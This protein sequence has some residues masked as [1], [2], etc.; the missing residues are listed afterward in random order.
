[1][2]HDDF[3]RQVKEFEEDVG[4]GDVLYVA[5][6]E[7]LEED[8][9]DLQK[10]DKKRVKRAVRAFLAVWGRMSRNV[11]R[12]DFNWDLLLEKIRDL[13]DKPKFLGK[14][15]LT[16]KLDNEAKIMAEMYNQLRMK[17]LSATGIS[18]VMHLLNPEVFVMWDDDI[19]KKIR[20]NHFSASANGYLDFLTWIQGELKEAI[21]GLSEDEIRKKINGPYIDNKTLAKLADEYCWWKVR[22]LKV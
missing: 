5:V 16:I 13:G 22:H 20:P 7:E 14:N 2:K 1:M 9:K 8:I 10:L 17:H 19:R 4:I 3:V 15:I 6:I 12:R 11:E 18:K 21:R